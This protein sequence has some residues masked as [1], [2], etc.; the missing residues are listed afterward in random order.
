MITPEH[1]E[2]LLG[3]DAEEPVLV[4][5]LGA[6]EV[7]PRSALGTDQYKGALEVASREDLVGRLGPGAPSRNDLEELSARLDST[8]A[9]LGA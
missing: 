6:A 3:S 4:V 9:H 7:V 5:V 1:V 8:V 2:A